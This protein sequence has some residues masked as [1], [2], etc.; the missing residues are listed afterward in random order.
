MVST[1]IILDELY[2]SYQPHISHVFTLCLLEAPIMNEI[3]MAIL[4]FRGKRAKFHL[5]SNHHQGTDAVNM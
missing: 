3:D 4:Q 2:L 1:G 5:R